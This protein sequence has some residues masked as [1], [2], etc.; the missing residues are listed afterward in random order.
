MYNKSEMVSTQPH[1]DNWVA[2]WLRSSRSD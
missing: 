1:K 2:T